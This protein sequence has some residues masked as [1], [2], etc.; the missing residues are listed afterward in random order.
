RPGIRRR[1]DI[2][3]VICRVPI[4]WPPVAGN[5]NAQPYRSSSYRIGRRRANRLCSGRRRTT[6]TDTFCTIKAAGF[7]VSAKLLVVVYVI[8]EHGYGA[9]QLYSAVSASRSKSV[10]PNIDRN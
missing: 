5:G 6:L 10:V 3:S 2:Q 9:D 7:G 1:A 4:A 8:R